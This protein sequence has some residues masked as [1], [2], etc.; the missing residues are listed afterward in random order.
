MD[1]DDERVEERKAKLSAQL[2]ASLDQNIVAQ[3]VEKIAS[4]VF[5][6]VANAGDNVESSLL[7]N[8]LENVKNLPSVLRNQVADAIEKKVLTGV[9]GCAQRE[10]QEPTSKKSRNSIEGTNSSESNRGISYSVILALAAVAEIK[11]GDVQPLTKAYLEE[12][13]SLSSADPLYVSQ[14][15]EASLRAVEKVYAAAAPKSP[16]P[17]NAK[18]ARKGPA[19]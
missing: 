18:Q 2:A 19:R 16:T 7:P 5:L 3:D 4:D 14:C 11:K 9:V 1:F 10:K 8:A 17:K 12:T 13:A 15:D 6:M